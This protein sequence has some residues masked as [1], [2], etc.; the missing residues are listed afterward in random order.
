M[1]LTNITTVYIDKAIVQNYFQGNNIP[2][3]AQSIPVSGENIKL[4]KVIKQ[5]EE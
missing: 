1:H 2:V 3:Q 4:Y 5:Y